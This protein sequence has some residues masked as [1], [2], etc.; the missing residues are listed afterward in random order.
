MIQIDG[1]KRQVYIKLADNAC[2]QALLRDKCGQ[3]EYR[4]NTGE[5]SIVSIV[6]AGMGTKKY[7]LQTYRLKCP[8]KH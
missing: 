1:Q 5:I 8:M 6:M 7:G 2:V 4:H 3:A